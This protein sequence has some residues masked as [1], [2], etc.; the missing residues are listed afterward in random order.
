MNEKDIT[1][2]IACCGNVCAICQHAKICSGCRSTNNTLCRHCT[3]E[4]CYQYYC[5]QQKGI[6]GCWECDDS[7][8]DHD[9]FS[10]E[11]TVRNRAFVR[12]AKYEGVEELGKCVFINWMRGISYRDGKDY[13]QF[14]NENDVVHLLTKHYISKD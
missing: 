5:C 3:K 8:C 12:F 1:D 7:P 14:T 6:E 10:H 13:D 9:M 11:H 2:S 4:G